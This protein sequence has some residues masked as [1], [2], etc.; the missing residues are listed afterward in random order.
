MAC[1]CIKEVNEALVDSNTRLDVPTVANLLTGQLRSDRVT[2]S[3]YKRDS[4]KRGSLPK[5]FAVYC[6]FCGKKYQEGNKVNG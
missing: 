3:T 4:K 1:N 2:I 5:I 6:P